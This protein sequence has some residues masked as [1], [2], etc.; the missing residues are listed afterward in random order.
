MPR[1]TAARRSRFVAARREYLLSAYGRTQPLKF[2]FLEHAQEFGLRGQ[3]HLADFV[4]DST[5]PEA[6]S[7]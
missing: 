6:S 5:P 4:E 3:T 1:S 2:V 7:I